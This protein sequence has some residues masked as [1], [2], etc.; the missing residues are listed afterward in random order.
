MKTVRW[1]IAALLVLAALTGC[2]LFQKRATLAIVNNSS[3]TI[4]VVNIS[5]EDDTS[6]GGD[7][8]AGTLVSGGTDYFE[9]IRAGTYDLRAQNA[10]A[11]TWAYYGAVLEPDEVWTWTLWD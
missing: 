6:W 10:S 11:I 9:D 7:Y 8:L 3:Y 4:T 2:S 5:P 1:T